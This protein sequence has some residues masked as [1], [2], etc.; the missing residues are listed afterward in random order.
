[1]MD[2]HDTRYMDLNTYI[3]EDVLTPEPR[4]SYGDTRFSMKGWFRNLFGR[5]N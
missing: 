5:K 1:M 3:A 4:D 2:W